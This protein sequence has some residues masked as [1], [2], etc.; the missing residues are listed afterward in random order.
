MILFETPGG[1]I[2]EAD[3]AYN[4]STGEL[5]PRTQLSLYRLG[6]RGGKHYLFSGTAEYADD[7]TSLLLR[8]TREARE[9]IPPTLAEARARRAAS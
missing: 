3:A 5:Q 1:V 9:Q 4:G 7:L 2:A 8:L 6:P